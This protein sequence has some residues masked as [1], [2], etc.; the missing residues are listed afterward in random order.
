MEF[1]KL[2]PREIIIGSLTLLICGSFLWSKLTKKE[3]QAAEE[4]PIVTTTIAPTTPKN[5][6]LPVDIKSTIPDD[7]EMLN[8]MKEQ[9]DKDRDQQRRI[10][11]L[12][13]K[14]E[15]T[16]LELKEQQALAEINKLRK[17]N[18][19][20]TKN[21]GSELNGEIPEMK[22]LYIGGTDKSKEAI[23]SINN[24]NYTVKEKMTPLKNVEII[25][26]TDKGVNV[27]FTGKEISDLNIVYRSE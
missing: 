18:A 23:L 20:F 2:R 9:M 11:A 26:I 5:P 17:S 19:G 4:S 15:Q 7:D 6:V 22:V 13:L 8:K 27:R 25:S 12:R 24:T 3:V 21:E 10:K 14:I 16:D 1:K